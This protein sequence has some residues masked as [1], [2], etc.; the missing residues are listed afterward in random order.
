MSSGW[1]QNVVR[2][3]EPA[4]S[5]QF[6]GRLVVQAAAR[7]EPGRKLLLELDPRNVDVLAGELLTANWTVTVGADLTGRRRFLSAVR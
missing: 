3:A 4:V 7:L 6:V 5:L 1:I 2:Q